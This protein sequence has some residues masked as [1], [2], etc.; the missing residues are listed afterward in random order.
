MVSSYSLYS[1]YGLGG[2]G[3]VVLKKGKQNNNH[4][5]YE[6]TTN[7]ENEKNINI[8][9]RWTEMENLHFFKFMIC[10]YNIR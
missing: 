4:R 5:K 3:E 6:K 2:G 8:Y 10:V 1:L 9:C 7:I